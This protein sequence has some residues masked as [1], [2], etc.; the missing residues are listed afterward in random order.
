[1][2]RFAADPEIAEEQEIARRAGVEMKR[3][4]RTGEVQKYLF[5]LQDSE[6]VRLEGVTIRMRLSGTSASRTAPVWIGHSSVFDLE[7]V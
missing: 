7:P 6:D 5:V 2:R 4:Y 1:M 3:Y